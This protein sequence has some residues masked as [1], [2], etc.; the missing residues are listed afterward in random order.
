MCGN[1]WKT[2]RQIHAIYRH[3]MKFEKIRQKCNRLIQSFHGAR[4]AF[5]GDTPVA[6]PGW[7]DQVGGPPQES[8]LI[9][10]CRT[11][12]EISRKKQNRNCAEILHPLNTSR[13]YPH[14]RCPPKCSPAPSPPGTYDPRDFVL[15]CSC[16]V[17][18]VLLLLSPVF[19]ASPWAEKKKQTQHIY[20]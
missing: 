6:T 2:H 15:G 14:P 5:W 8:S 18:F 17:L 9:E 12:M 4:W 13:K 11:Y 10:I 16:C 19:V 3:Y 1:S 20:T 7:A